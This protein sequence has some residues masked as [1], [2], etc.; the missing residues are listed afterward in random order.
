MY[1]TA[2]DDAAAVKIAEWMLRFP[3][4]LRPKEVLGRAHV[5][6]KD[7]EQV[8]K[9]VPNRFTLYHERLKVVGTATA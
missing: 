3:P 2:A 9:C 6:E 4:E 7:D 8:V 1:G 5:G